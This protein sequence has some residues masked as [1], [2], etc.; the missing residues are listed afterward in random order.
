MDEHF[1]SSGENQK[2]EQ[3]ALSK[4]RR[5]LVCEKALRFF[6]NMTSATSKGWPDIDGDVFLQ[7]LAKAT[8]TWLASRSDGWSL[9][10]QLLHQLSVHCRLE[11]MQRESHAHADEA[12]NGGEILPVDE[13]VY[14]SMTK[15]FDKFLMAFQRASKSGAPAMPGPII[16]RKLADSVGAYGR[17]RKNLVAYLRTFQY[18]LLDENF[19]LTPTVQGASRQ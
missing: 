13:R 17:K 4:M 1:N 6:E 12:L 7:G 8:H 15:E 11:R 14:L 18:N 9:R 16:V 3:S 19:T 10:A 2:P 5:A